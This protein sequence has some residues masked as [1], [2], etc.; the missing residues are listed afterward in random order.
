MTETSFG[1]REPTDGRVLE[2]RELDLIVVPGVAFDRSCH[3]VG[4]GAGFY[5]RLLASTRDGT[6]AVAIAF[7]M[8]VVEEVPTGPL[9]RPV[10]AI[11]TEDD[12]I[13]CR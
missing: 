7:G 6:A 11:V 8:Q 3:R 10:D 1:S 9:D 5:D 2:A 12:V 13:R 4:Y